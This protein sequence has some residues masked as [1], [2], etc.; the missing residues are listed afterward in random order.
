MVESVSRRRPS[1]EGWREKTRDWREGKSTHEG[2]ESVLD[3]K[4]FEPLSVPRRQMDGYRSSDALTVQKDG[5]LLKLRVRE[6]VVEGGLGVQLKTAFRGRSLTVTVSMDENDAQSGEEERQIKQLTLG[7]K[8][9]GH[10]PSS[11]Q[12][13]QTQSEVGGPAQGRSAT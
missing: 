9:Q 1:K 3:Y 12:Q 6:D 5:R 10:S 8:E 13:K 4:S 11:C 2:E 7:T